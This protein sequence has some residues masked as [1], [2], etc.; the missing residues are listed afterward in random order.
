LFQINLKT[1]HDLF[2]A[3]ASLLAMSV[4]DIACFLSKRVALESI[5]SKLAPTMGLARDS[6]SQFSA[7]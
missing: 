7:E 2:S 3:E 6:V 5:A 4:N 1:V